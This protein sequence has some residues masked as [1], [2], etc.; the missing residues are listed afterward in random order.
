M[1]FR[2]IGLD[3]EGH[4]EFNS[5]G[6]PRRKQPSDDSLEGIKP[7]GWTEDVSQVI[8]NFL[9]G[10]PRRLGRVRGICVLQDLRGSVFA[11]H[12]QNKVRDSVFGD[13]I[14]AFEMYTYGFSV[15]AYVLLFP[16]KA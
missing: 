7:R 16:I 10:G 5:R 9:L 6:H 12:F 2:L 1:R 8:L 11:E 15:T 3:E 4:R 14:T 13:H